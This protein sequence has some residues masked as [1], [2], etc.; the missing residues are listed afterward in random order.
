[1]QSHTETDIDRQR[2]TYREREPTDTYMQIERQLQIDLE[3]GMHGAVICTCTELHGETY[4]Q[5]GM[6]T[7]M[8]AARAIH[9]L[10]DIYTYTSCRH[11][12][13]DR[14]AD[15]ASQTDLCTHIHSDTCRYRQRV[16]IQAATC[17]N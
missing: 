12:Q 5:P 4:I 13:S 8:H 6:Q 11:L 2:Y 1:M 14:Q 7:G 17:R 15:T 16:H 10:T 3:A 9:A